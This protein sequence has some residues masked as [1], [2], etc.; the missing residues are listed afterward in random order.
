[1]KQRYPVAHTGRR[2]LDIQQHRP[3]IDID[4]P[5]IGRQPVNAGIIAANAIEH[6]TI[7]RSNPRRSRVGS[8]FHQIRTERTFS[9][10]SRVIKQPQPRRLRIGCQG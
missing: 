8:G 5:A 1:M 9:Q 10:M 7:P 2:E 3:L 6:R 4:A